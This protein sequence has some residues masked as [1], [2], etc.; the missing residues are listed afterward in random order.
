MK[1]VIDS[2]LNRHLKAISATENLDRAN[3]WK[4]PG[5]YLYVLMSNDI[6]TAVKFSKYDIQVN[7]LLLN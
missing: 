7:F 1:F 5:Y 3:I 4:M 2:D 6:K